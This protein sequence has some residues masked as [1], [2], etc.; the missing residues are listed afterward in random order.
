MF[1]VYHNLSFL[2]MGGE[3]WDNRMNTMDLPANVLLVMVDFI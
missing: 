2:L 3:S 1:V